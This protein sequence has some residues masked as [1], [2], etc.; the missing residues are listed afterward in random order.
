MAHQVPLDNKDHNGNTALHLAA[1]T[2]NATVCS[3]LLQH[4][5]DVTL[6]VRLNSSCWKPS[7]LAVKMTINHCIYIHN[8]T[9][10]TIMASIQCSHIFFWFL[11]QRIPSLILLHKSVVNVYTLFV[12]LIAVVLLWFWN[13]RMTW[14]RRHG[15]CVWF[16][17][18]WHVLSTF[19][20]MSLASAWPPTSPDE[21]RN[22]RLPWQTTM[23][24]ESTLSEF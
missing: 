6:K 4:G 7:L 13:F 10:T 17:G 16:V 19:V 8:M 18:T 5:G 15:R 20:C 9:T 2:G 23:T 1:R 14:V 24:L 11:M 3:I 12:I 21:R 22:W